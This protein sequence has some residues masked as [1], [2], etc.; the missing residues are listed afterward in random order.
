MLYTKLKCQMK[1]QAPLRRWPRPHWPS[2]SAATWQLSP[3]SAPSSTS[4][5][6]PLVAAQQLPPPAWPP[7]PVA[8]STAA[9]IH[10]HIQMHARG[11]GEKKTKQSYWPSPAV[12][13]ELLDVRRPAGHRHCGGAWGVRAAFQTLVVVRPIRILEIL[14]ETLLTWHIIIHI[15]Q[16]YKNQEK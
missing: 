10:A 4:P 12:P 7:P 8:L 11:W 9:A 5:L 2:L 15:V 13:K 1:R 3:S 14:K 6:P 16:K